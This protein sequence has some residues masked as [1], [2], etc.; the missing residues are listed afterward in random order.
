MIAATFRSMIPLLA[1]FGRRVFL[2][3]IFDL[4]CSVVH[5][6]SRIRL[7]G[8][9]RNWYEKLSRDQRNARD[10]EAGAD[11][12]LPQAAP[13]HASQRITQE[14]VRLTEATYG[15]SSIGRAS[16]SKSEGWGFKSLRPCFPAGVL[17]RC[18]FS[19]AIRS[20][21]PLYGKR[22]ERAATL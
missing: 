10:G 18:R 22:D 1:G 11:E 5:H 17:A 15:R 13:S 12:I 16:D 7:A 6:G 4:F 19:M 14:V 20:P 2:I 8:M 21:C 3:Q 9:L